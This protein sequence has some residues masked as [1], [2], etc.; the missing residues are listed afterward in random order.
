MVPGD[1]T[2]PE[3]TGLLKHS[4]VEQNYIHWLLQ[5]FWNID[6]LTVLRVFPL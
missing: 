5:K 1:K 2:L 6:F 4:L 3:S